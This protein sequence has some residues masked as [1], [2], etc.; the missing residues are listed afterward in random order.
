MSLSIDL[1]FDSLIASIIVRSQVLQAINNLSHFHRELQSN[2][3]LLSWLD[4][5]SESWD[6]S[7]GPPFYQFPSPGSEFMMN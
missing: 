5:I 7:L 2:L 3:A 4:V 6:Q 1:M